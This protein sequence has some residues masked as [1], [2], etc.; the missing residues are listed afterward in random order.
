MSANLQNFFQDLQKRG[1]IANVANLENFYQLKPAE[2]VIYLGIDCTGENLH[3][4]H[5]FLYFQTVRF[6]KEGFTVLLVLGGATSRIGDPSDKDKERPLLEE[7]QIE[8]Y[9]EKIK[10]QLE[11]VLIKPKKIGEANFSP[12]EQF[13]SDTPELL[14]KIYRILKI[15]Q[16]DKKEQQ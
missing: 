7:K 6:A 5:L 8:N 15:N 9:Q 14:N 1:V 13:Y 2:K 3:I 11:R 4:G 10:L 16:N 12:L